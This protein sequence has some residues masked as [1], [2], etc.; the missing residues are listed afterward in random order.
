[1]VLPIIAPPLLLTEWCYI[2]T[3][4]AKADAK[5]RSASDHHI[6]F[7]FRT[8]MYSRNLFVLDFARRFFV[9]CA[10]ISEAYAVRTLMKFGCNWRKIG[11]K[12]KCRKD[13]ESTCC[14]FLHKNSLEKQG[15]T[16]YSLCMQFQ[17]YL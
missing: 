3:A 12:G 5:G 11:R 14:Y 6:F 2:C 9:S 13:S 4:A 7:S 15:C 16:S 10:Q 17:A 1:M 8:H